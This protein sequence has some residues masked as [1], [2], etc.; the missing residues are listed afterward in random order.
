MKIIVVEDEFRSRNGIVNLLKKTK[1]EYEV[2]AVAEDGYEGMDL[3]RQLKPD[4]VITDI[5][6]PK[7]SGLEMIENLRNS[8]IGCRFVIL[9]G[10]ADFKYAQAG[11]KLGVVDYLL[12][13]ITYHN[14]AEVMERVEKDIA[15]EI[16]K[17]KRTEKVIPDKKV[18][19]SAYSLLVTKMISAVETRYQEKLSLDVFS[20]KYN[21][22][23]EYLSAIFSKE[24]G[25][26]FVNYLRDI[27]IARAKELLM[28]SNKK[29]YE[30][31]FEVGYNDSKYFCRIFKEA[32]GVSPKDYCKY[33]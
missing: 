16:N 2:V 6:M 5:Q 21:V 31:A 8:G 22:T 29:V 1:E 27:R 15:M 13:P 14:L 4:V 10:Y 28:N 11:I 26:A 20:E 7:I 24:T 9:S 3:V 33:Q 32:V 17:K 18:E 23:P 19:E 25:K 12:K 30:I